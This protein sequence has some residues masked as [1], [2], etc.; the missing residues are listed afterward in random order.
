MEGEGGRKVGTAQREGPPWSVLSP[1][2]YPTF[3]LNKLRPMM[4]RRHHLLAQAAVGALRERPVLFKYCAEEV[5]TARH[6]ALFQVR[7]GAGQRCSVFASGSFLWLILLHIL[8]AFSASS[9]L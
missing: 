7:Q 2:L 3:T 1:C 6:N 9:R 4:C 5:A 8:S